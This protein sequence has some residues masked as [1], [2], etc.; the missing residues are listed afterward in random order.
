MYFTSTTII[1]SAILFRGFKGTPTSIVTIVLGFLTICSGVVLLQLSKSAKDVPDTAV[2]AGDLD[3]MRTI[4]EQEQPETEPKADAIRGASIIVRRFSV[5]R[6]KMEMEE[7]RRLHEE[8]QMD[9]QPLGEGEQYQWDGLRRR[10]TTLYSSPSTRSRGSTLQTPSEGF[11]AHTGPLSRS[12]TMT[13]AKHPPLGMSRFPDID[14]QQ[15]ISSDLESRPDTGSSFGVSLL[16]T[17]RAARKKSASTRSGNAPSSGDQMYSIAL[18]GD[19][20]R[21]QSEPNSATNHG[22]ARATSRGE[23]WTKHVVFADGAGPSEETAHPQPPSKTAKR[24]FSFN[25]LRPSNESLTE[26]SREM[27]EVDRST[28]SGESSRG[29]I[30]SGHSR[31]RSGGSGKHMRGATEEERLGLVKA[32][33]ILEE[34]DEEDYEAAPEKETSRVI[35]LKESSKHSSQDDMDAPRTP[36]PRSPRQPGRRAHYE[37]LYDEPDESSSPVPPRIHQRSYS[38]ESTQYEQ[39][40]LRWAQKQQGR[41]SPAADS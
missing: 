21:S 36:S 30:L 39:Q 16:G 17:I 29:G 25:F 28:M 18:G 20:G 9:L 34:E 3:Q 22:R 10:R 13:G 26:R 40:R 1:T 15:T 14:D 32:E 35:E 41:R 33:H 8:R 12:T 38:A 6:H 5:A 4:A 7:A 37:I 2:F 11:V 31:Q 24:Q 27:R 19:Q 23:R